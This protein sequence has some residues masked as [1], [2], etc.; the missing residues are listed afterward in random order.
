M[1]PCTPLAGSPALRLGEGPVWDAAS[2]RLWWVDIL[3]GRVYGAGLDG[4][5]LVDVSSRQLDSMV[6]AVA[7]AADGGLMVAGKSA[8][9]RVD[10]RFDVEDRWEVLP[11][12]GVRRLNDGKCDP[13]GRYLVGS[14]SLGEPDGR[15]GL[16]SLDS[17]GELTTLDEDL[18]LSNGLAWSVDGSRLYSIDT[19]RSVVFVR[20]YDVATGW[21]GARSVHAEVDGMPDGMAMDADDH[22]WIAMWGAGEVRRLDPAGRVVDTFAVPTEQPTCVAFVGPSLDRLVITTAR[23]GL[24]PD[25]LAAQPHA[26]ELF[27]ADPGVTGA[28][29]AAWVPPTLRT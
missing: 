6:G 28:P 2:Q 4:E 21:V 24:D 7:P 8:L 27:V 19:L 17:G 23:D 14:L 11:D 20:E 18:A 10:G 16:W 13:A 29:V 1:I 22:L 26:G 25:R 5:T 12:D 9:I 3:D 15:N